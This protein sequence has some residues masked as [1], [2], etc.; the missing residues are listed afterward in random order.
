MRIQQSRR[1]LKARSLE[2]VQMVWKRRVKVAVCVSRVGEAEKALVRAFSSSLTRA[3]A[4]RR[5]EWRRKRK[6][7]RMDR[8]SFTM[9]SLMLDPGRSNKPVA[10]WAANYWC[11]RG[12]APL[13]RARGQTR[14]VPG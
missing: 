5:R 11:A 8:P 7:L 9:R 6:Y 3:K 4:G 10:V 12:A 13:S 1:T 14:G 2:P